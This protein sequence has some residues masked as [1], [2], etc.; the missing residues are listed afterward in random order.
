MPALP[1]CLNCGL[2]VAIPAGDCP[3]CGLPV[4]ERI[5]VPPDSKTPTRLAQFPPHLYQRTS[6]VAPGFYADTPAGQPAAG[7]HRGRQ[8]GMG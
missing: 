7:R 4:A 2:A 5:P 3:R 6:S 1:R 8:C